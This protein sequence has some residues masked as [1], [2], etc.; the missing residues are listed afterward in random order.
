MKWHTAEECACG[1]KGDLIDDPLYRGFCKVCDDECCS[2]C[3]LVE[4][5]VDGNTYLCAMHAD[6]ES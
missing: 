3:G 4:G 6:G 5:D 1:A 2:K